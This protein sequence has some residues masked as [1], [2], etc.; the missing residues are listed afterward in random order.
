MRSKVIDF[1]AFREL[2]VVD[3]SFSI[4]LEE[5]TGDGCPEFPEQGGILF[6]GNALYV[7]D[8]S[9]RLKIIK[10]LHDEGHVGCDKTH[11]LVVYGFNPRAPID[12]VP[13]PDLKR[14]NGKVEEFMS[15]LQQIHR[16]TE[17]RLHGTT[18]KYK[19]A[20]DKKCRNVEFEVAQGTEDGPVEIIEKINPNGYH[21]KLPSHVRTADAFN[22][23][24]LIPFRGDSSSDEDA[25]SR[26]NFFLNGEDDAD[27]IADLMS[28]LVVEILMA[29]FIGMALSYG[30]SLNTFHSPELAGIW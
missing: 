26:A 22:V 23:K 13:V 18:A 12:L 2:L 1:D 14:A 3:P 5:L 9:L 17:Q 28:K 21:L 7:P 6:K 25:N 19:E 29:G 20:A 27:V 16:D 10:E 15:S 30:L 11:I 4:I 8:S 24:H